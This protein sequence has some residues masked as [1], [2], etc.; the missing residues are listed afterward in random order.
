MC[1]PIGD[2]GTRHVRTNE[3]RN[4]LYRDTD[5]ETDIMMRG[6]ERHGR[7]KKNEK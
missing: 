4:N 6:L 7:L 2:K 3:E 1:V 5:T